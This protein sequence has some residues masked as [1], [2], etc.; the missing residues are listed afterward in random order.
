MST[1]YHNVPRC[2]Q[3]KVSGVQCDSP[4]LKS[5]PYCYFHSRWHQDHPAAATPTTTTTTDA[6]TLPQFPPLED[7]NAIQFALMQVANLILHNR[8]D[9]KTANSLLYTLQLAAANLKQ[10]AFE[11]YNAERTVVDPETVAD[12]P[13]R[14]YAWSARD[15]EPTQ[16]TA[17]SKSP[18]AE[19]LINDLNPLV[20]KR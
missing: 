11:A 4:A 3:I 8:I 13:L 6:P 15:F 7:A 16:H 2:T 12:N 20:G 18:S 10:T 1:Q 9:G 19:K 5:R 17:P 14:G